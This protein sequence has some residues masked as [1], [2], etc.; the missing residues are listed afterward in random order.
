V[1]ENPSDTSFPNAS[2]P[3][4]NFVPV[5]SCFSDSY[6]SGILYKVHKDHW[7]LNYNVDSVIKP[8]DELQ[9]DIIRFNDI[10][11]T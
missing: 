3:Q 9:S 10:L 6:K 5:T 8:I 4:P 1:D 2:S 7:W 11:C